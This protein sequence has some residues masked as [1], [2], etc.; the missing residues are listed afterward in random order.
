MR[1][2]AIKPLREFWGQNHDAEVALRA[3]VA[4]ATYANW[5]KPSDIKK[6]FGSVSIIANNRAIFN[7][8]GNKYRLVVAIK[9]DF[10][11]I[12]IRFIGTHKQYD[13]II[14]KEI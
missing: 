1:V 12:Y 10:Q 4:E 11:L 8:S 14:A 9:Y 3:W 7:I 2:I 6:K 13:K 5:Q